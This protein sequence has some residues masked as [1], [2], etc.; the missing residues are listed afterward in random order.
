MVKKK[1]EWL[2][3]SIIVGVVIVLVFFYLVGDLDSSDNTNYNLNQAPE[4]TVSKPYCGDGFCNSNEDCSSC[5]SDCGICE[6]EI[7]DKIKETIVW[8]KYDITGKSSDG[9]YFETGGTGSGQCGQR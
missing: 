5:S 9:S 6:K 1:K 8:V 2:L 7:L 3:P 4:D